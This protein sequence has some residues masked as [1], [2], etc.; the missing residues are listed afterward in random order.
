MCQ[1]DQW[2]AVRPLEVHA[3]LDKPTDTEKYRFPFAAAISRALE[4]AYFR[5][6]RRFHRSNG[7]VAEYK[8]QLL[9]L[10]VCVLSAAVGAR[11]GDCY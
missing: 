8:F 11:G 1:A 9:S 7:L 5:I 4:E 10:R 2:L 6:S 3:K